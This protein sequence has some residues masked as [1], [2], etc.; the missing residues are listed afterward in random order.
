MLGSRLGSVPFAS[1]PGNEW[2]NAERRR[3][4]EVQFESTDPMHL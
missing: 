1:P 2:L 4:S 3:L